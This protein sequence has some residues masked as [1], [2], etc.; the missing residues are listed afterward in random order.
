MSLLPV[1]S[2][3]WYKDEVYLEWTEGVDDVVKANLDNS[4][5]RRGRLNSSRVEPFARHCFLPTTGTTPRRFPI[6]VKVDEFRK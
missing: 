2:L 5:G 6:V 3:H 4:N 1:T